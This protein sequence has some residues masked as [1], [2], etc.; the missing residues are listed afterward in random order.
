[1]LPP[2]RKEKGVGMCVGPLYSETPFYSDF[3]N[4][5][6][7]LGVNHFYIYASNADWIYDRVRT[8]LTSHETGYDA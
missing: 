2:G 1:M 5:Y 8:F 6:T 3:L 4:W 7:E